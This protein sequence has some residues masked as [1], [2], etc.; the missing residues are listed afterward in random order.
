MKN[1]LDLLATDLWLTVCVNQK[2]SVTKL[3]ALLDFDARD[4]VTIDGIDVLPR[5]Q[6]LAVDGR[7]TIPVPFYQ[8]YHEVSGQGWLLKPQ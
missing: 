6:H 8:W 1:F 7:L 4:T 5:Y 3:H 2:Q